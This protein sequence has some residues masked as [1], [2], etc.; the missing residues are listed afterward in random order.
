[1]KRIFIAL[2]AVCI[3]VLGVFAYV[4][5]ERYET[6][7]ARIANV[8]EFQK[9]AF[10]GYSKLASGKFE[11]AKYFYERAI[12]LHDRDPKTFLHYSGVLARLGQNKEAALALEKAYFNANFKNE[13]TL[14]QVAKMFFEIGDYEKSLKYHK[15][16][17]E[18]FRPKYKY[19]EKIVL[20][21]HRL[22]RTDEAMGYFAYIQERD[23]QYFKG[24]EE[25]LKFAKL[26]TEDTKALD[27]QPK[28]DVTEGV[29]ALLTLGIEYEKQGLSVKA[30]EAYDKLLLS[31]PNHQ[32]ANKNIAALL[33]SY[34]DYSRA[35]RHLKVL[36]DDS[37]DT[38]FKIGGVYHQMKSYDKAI[39]YYEK[40]LK[41][42]KSVLLLRNLAS[43]S[44]RAGDKE[45]TL[46][47]ASKLREMS[48]KEAHSFE[49]MT[50]VSLGE[51]MSKRDKLEFQAINT[52]Y[53]IRE[54]LKF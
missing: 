8:L 26:Y 28:Y 1:L 16:A 30:L 50:I 15:E 35:L 29:E 48:P 43:T 12:E 41:K 46:K 17:I 21:L 38:L 34:R 14:T 11:E 19:I 51:E 6:R 33:I 2:V 52:L 25:F 49:Y 9:L 3:L 27:L 4:V 10:A 13:E 22:G 5:Y 24:K 20:S 40:A 45:R 31:E 44:L 54:F 53:K 47:Y 7:E 42:D 37:F 36:E 18:R 39:E 23:P 32:E